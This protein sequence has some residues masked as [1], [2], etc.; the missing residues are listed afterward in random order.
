MNCEGRGYC[1]VLKLDSTTGTLVRV[2]G[3][4]IPAMIGDN[5][6]N[7]PATNAHLWGPTAIA[8]DRSGALYIVESSG[9]RVRKVSNGVI[10][11]FAGG[12]SDYIGEGVTATSASL[13]SPAGI[14]VD[15]SRAAARRAPG[16]VLL[17]AQQHQGNNQR[18]ARLPHPVRGRGPYKQRPHSPLSRPS[19]SRSHA[20]A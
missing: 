5:G 6:D 8:L 11:T 1:V 20:S 7:G 12:G 18:E 2:A 4:G 15:S 16:L 14:A 3:N 9:D 13:L 10:T 17:P 19:F